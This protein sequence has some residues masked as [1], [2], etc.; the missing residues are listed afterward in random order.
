L[1]SKLIWFNY[2]PCRVGMSFT[3]TLVLALT[4]GVVGHG[5][6]PEHE[7][8]RINVKPLREV[9]GIAASRQHDDVL[10]MHND[11]EAK[12]VYAV[13]TSGKVAAQ[14][15]VPAAV[16]DVE[17]MAIGPG[18]EK[19]VDYLYLGDIGDNDGNRDE[20][21][22][23]RFAEPSLTDEDRKPKARGAEVIR[24]KYPD[25]AHD[26]EAFMVDSATGD[27]IIVTKEVGRA[28]TYVARAASLQNPGGRV[29]LEH[30]ADLAADQ[31]S[32]GDISP[33][34]LWILLRNEEQGWLWDRLP[35]ESLADAFQR[36]PQA[37]PVRG[38]RQGANGESIGFA[39]SGQSYFTVSEGKDER[40]Y[41]FDLPAV[42]ASPVG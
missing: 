4:G 32:A 26:A 3:L 14:V 36:P 20:V 19:G 24:L 40:I 6:E 17:D 13:K 16:E 28:P 9:S 30:L 22:V 18:P 34:G 37:V 31:V 41:E 21:R 2:R 42:A 25:G 39:P 10:W 11:G 29:A 23:V 1:K 5:A 35:G 33:D 38:Q 15:K 12:H 8:G 7:L 27:L